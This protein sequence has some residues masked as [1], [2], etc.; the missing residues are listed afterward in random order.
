M[1]IVDDLVAAPFRGL[2]WVMKEIVEAAEQEAEAEAPLAGAPIRP[3]PVEAGQDQRQE[4][5]RDRVGEEE[6]V[7]DRDLIGDGEEAEG[8]AE[9]TQEESRTPMFDPRADEG[10]EG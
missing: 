5:D 7:D 3:S 8:E 9:G 1:L 10:E 6:E 2:L 4:L